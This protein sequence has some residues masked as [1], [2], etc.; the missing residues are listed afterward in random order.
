MKTTKELLIIDN[1]RFCDIQKLIIRQ[2]LTMLYSNAI[3]YL[4]QVEFDAEKTITERFFLHAEKKY[5]P[6]F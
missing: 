4:M 5:L 2:S 3:L 1:E 6:T